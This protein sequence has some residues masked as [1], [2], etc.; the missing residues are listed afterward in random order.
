MGY[1]AGSVAQRGYRLRASLA[2]RPA[3][4]GEDQC[5]IALV[6][7]ERARPLSALKCS[8]LVEGA[9]VLKG[10]MTVFSEMGRDRPIAWVC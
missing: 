5:M 2:M 6:S 8:S 9:A 10:G 4:M 7:H 1:P 3:A